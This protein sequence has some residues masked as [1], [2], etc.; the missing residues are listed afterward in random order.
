MIP[1]FTLFVAIVLYRIVAAYG[2]AEHSWL[3]N[4]SP[5][6]ALALCGPL[7]F[8]RRLALVLPMVILL[9]SDMVLNAHFGAALVTAEMLARYAALVLVALLGLRLRECR[10]VGPFLLA[11][12]AG[13]TGFYLITNTVSWLTAPEYA[14][15]AV[16]WWQALTLGLP[17][18][19]PTWLFFR[20]SLVSD[21]CFTLAIL[22]C[23]AFAASTKVN[24][25]L[26]S[27]LAVE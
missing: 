21:A 19:P 3:L 26:T 11:S 22:G 18:Y 1:A 25:V 24:R 10:K 17:G 23:L 4:F 15:T 13:S 27:R 14:K 8:P 7:I 5:V 9:V 2:G 16:G 20:N 12:A 6:A